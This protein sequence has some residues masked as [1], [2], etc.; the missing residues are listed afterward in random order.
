[1]LPN[2]A[3]GNLHTQVTIRLILKGK[4]TPVDAGV[5]CMSMFVL[6]GVSFTHL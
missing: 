6:C 2:P 5:Y 1:M 4:P 3:L